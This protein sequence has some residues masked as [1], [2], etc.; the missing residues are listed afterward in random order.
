M[1]RSAQGS[2]EEGTA[3]FAHLERQLAAI[4]HGLHE[5]VGG[6]LEVGLGALAGAQQLLQ[7]LRQDALCTARAHKAVARRAAQHVLWCQ[8]L[9]PAPAEALRIVTSETEAEMEWQAR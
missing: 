7:D 8:L 9:H 2:A 5:R 4:E 1:Q 6:G 3:R